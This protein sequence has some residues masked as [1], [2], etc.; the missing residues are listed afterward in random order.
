[1]PV[2]APKARIGITI[3]RVFEDRDVGR[4]ALLTLDVVRIV[5]DI[6]QLVLRVPVG[7]PLEVRRS[8]G[9]GRCVDVCG[10]AI[11]LI[12]TTGRSEREEKSIARRTPW[13]CR[14]SGSCG[15]C[16]EASVASRSGCA[17]EAEPCEPAAWA[18][19]LRRR[20]PSPAPSAGSAVEV[21]PKP[22]ETTA[23]C[24]EPRMTIVDRLRWVVRR[25]STRCEGCRCSAQRARPTPHPTD[26]HQPGTGT[27]QATR[28]GRSDQVAPGNGP[29]QG[30]L[31]M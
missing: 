6:E 10:T 25:A 13:R 24:E 16:R 30:M 19:M 21:V 27:A 11:G 4:L 2:A 1:M 12:P 20:R 14:S 18:S 5:D 22:V 8:F 3:G 26:G 17:E 15:R 7:P 29:E 23:R 9:S 28:G 31:V